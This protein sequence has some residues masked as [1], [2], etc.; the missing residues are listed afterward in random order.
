[1]NILKRLYSQSAILIATHLST[2]SCGLVR[3]LVQGLGPAIQGS[4]FLDDRLGSRSHVGKEIGRNMG[5]TKGLE[6]LMAGA[7]GEIALAVLMF[8]HVGHGWH[9]SHAVIEKGTAGKALT[10]RH[11]FSS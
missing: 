11:G 8:H 4:A 9:I 6:D 5:R 3:T 1:L 2:A 10:I 7:N